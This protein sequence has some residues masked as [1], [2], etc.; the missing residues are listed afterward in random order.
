VF[1]DAESASHFFPDGYLAADGVAQALAG[2]FSHAFI[3]ELAHAALLDAAPMLECSV[4]TFAH[5][6]ARDLARRLSKLDGHSRAMRHRPPCSI[7]LFR[8][9]F[10]VFSDSGATSHRV[11]TCRPST[12]RRERP[13]EF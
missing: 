10:Q 11:K 3:D 4:K 1:F 2:E 8:Q 6:N 5:G 13:I 9:D 12:H 7:P